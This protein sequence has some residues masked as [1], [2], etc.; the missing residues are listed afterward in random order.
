MMVARDGIEPP[1][2]A[3]SDDLRELGGLRKF[4]KGRE[5]QILSWV[6]ILGVEVEMEAFSTDEYC[7]SRAP[8]SRSSPQV[9]PVSWIQVDDFFRI[10]LRV[11]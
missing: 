7:R 8:S 6:E 1:T 9:S 5:R 2:P 10:R 4:L 11:F 3:F